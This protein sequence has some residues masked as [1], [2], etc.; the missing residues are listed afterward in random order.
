ARL[1]LPRRQP[2]LHRPVGRRDGQPARQPRLR[3]RLPAARLLPLGLG[4]GGR[5]RRGG[6]PPRHRGRPAAGRGPRRPDRPPRPDARGERLGR[7]ALRLARRRG[8]ARDADDPPPRRGGPADRGD[9]GRLRP[10]PDLRGPLRGVDRRPRHRPEPEPGTPARRLPA[11]WSGRRR[12]LLALALGAVRLRRPHVRHLL[13]HPHPHP[14]RPVGTAA[15]KPHAGR[16]RHRRGHLV[17]PGAAVLPGADVVGRAGQPGH[18]RADVRGA[19]ADDPGGLPT[20]PD[21][22]GRDRG[23][24]RRHPGRPRRAVRHRPGAD[25][26]ADRRRLVGPGAAAGADDL[27]GQP[28]GRGRVLVLL[29]VPQPDRKRRH[30]CLPA[31]AHARAP[32]GARHGERAV[33]RGR[34][35]A[36]GSA[37]RGGPAAPLR[38]RVGG[39]GAAGGHAGA[40][41]L[42]DGQQVGAGSAPAQRV[43]PADAGGL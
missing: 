12:A 28:A 34:A 14:H 17:H 16:D 35:H 15:R 18:Q 20:G 26:R 10:R 37:A 24:H 29:P 36:P 43:A 2:R 1:P 27:V 22:P 5:L 40:G 13:P 9:R 31:G 7:A 42:P 25:R 33:P 21:R 6:P 11:R 8:P 23:G 38:R 32:A 3:L 30:R 39:H 19:A 4:P 41:R